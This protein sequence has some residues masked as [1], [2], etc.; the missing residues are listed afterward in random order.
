MN[1]FKYNETIE[2]LEID[3]LYLEEGLSYAY[4]NGYKNIRIFS[5][6]INNSAITLDLS[7]F[8]NKSFISSLIISDDFKVNKITNTEALYSLDNLES[9]SCSQKIKLDFSFL[10]KLKKL[11][12]LYNKNLI[13]LNKLV[14]VEDLFLRS[15]NEENCSIINKMKNVKKIRLLGSYTSLDGIEGMRR[16]ESLSLIFSPKVVDAL[17]INELNNLVFLYIEK[18]KNL[19]D[20]SF[21]NGNDSIEEIFISELDSVSFVPEMNKIKSIKFWNLKDGDLNKIL[22]SKTL[23]SVYFYPDKRNYNY[24]LD[25]ITEFLSNKSSQ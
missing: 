2:H 20:F 17:K 9:L 10:D 12:I 1:K 16:L 24:K 11:Y 7:A 23:K 15:F 4:N 25:E 3:P 14:F 13:N 5:L 6:N 22:K 18:C 8:Y 19:S 21:L